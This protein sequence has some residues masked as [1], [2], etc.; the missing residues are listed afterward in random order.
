MIPVQPHIRSSHEMGVELMA[1]KAGLYIQ[2]DTCPISV[3]LFI[4]FSDL[5]SGISQQEQMTV[6]VEVQCP[7]NKD[8]WSS[9]SGMSILEKR[10]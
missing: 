3:N 8:Y 2:S 4:L 1:T 5:A 7:Q 10:M 6:E 9:G